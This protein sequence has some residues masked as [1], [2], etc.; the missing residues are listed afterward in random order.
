MSTAA[1]A[2]R[3]LTDSIGSTRSMVNFMDGAVGNITDLLK[4]KGMWDDTIIFFQYI[5]NKASKATIQ[6][7]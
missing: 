3:R 7:S 4:S 5:S 6:N 1:L 2:L